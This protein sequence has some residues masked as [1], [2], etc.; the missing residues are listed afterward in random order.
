[1]AALALATLLPGTALAANECN[2]LLNISYPGAPAVSQVGDIL[3]VRFDLGTGSIVGGPANTLAL[4]RL[5]FDLD[6]L[7]GPPPTPNCPDEGMLVR[8]QGDATIVSNCPGVVFSSNVPAGGA[9]INHITFTA[10][11]APPGLVIPALQPVGPPGFCNLQFQIQILGPTV[12]ATGAIEQVVGYDLARCDN[13]VLVSGGFQ[14]GSIPVQLAPHFDCYQLRGGN[15]PLPKPV[16][17]LQDVFGSYTA[18]LKEADR[19]CA[20]TNKNGEDPL[21][22]GLPQHLTG[23]E[24]VNVVPNIPEP[25]DVQVLNQFGTYSVDVRNPFKLL[26]PTAKTLVPPPPMAIP[27]GIRHYLCHD[28]DGVQGPRPEGIT[29]QSQ[30]GPNVVRITDLNRA[31]LCAPVNK[32]NGDPGAVTDPSFLMCLRTNEQ[33]DFGTQNVF[34]FN[35]FGPST[36]QFTGPPF[37]TQY[38][39]LCLPSS[40]TIP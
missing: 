39:E 30:F 18:T 12:D 25:N 15:L 3:T 23:Y 27:A 2:G 33:L 36:T 29:V 6:C 11:P 26:V 20:P 16:V 22:P 5:G 35:Q 32:N 13:G 40:V 9:A 38:D 14:T 21:A 28:L 17:T 10:N 37:V 34:L 4:E 24:F 19:L 31:T 1:V 7:V 8:Y